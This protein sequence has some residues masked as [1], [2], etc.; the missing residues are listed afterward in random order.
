MTKVAVLGGTGYLA[1][2]IKS[3][4]TKKKNKFIFFSRK[5]NSKFY[6]NNILE[7]KNTKI[8]SDLKIIIHLAG[9][10]QLQLKKNVSLIK[11][12]NYITEKICDLCL[13]N[14][15]KLI[16][17][18]S[19]QVY[20]NYGKVDI[21]NN[22]KIDLKKSY[23]KSHIES[24]KII[25]QKFINKKNMFT[26]IRLGNVFGFKKYKNIREVNNNLINGFC[27]S[28]LKKKKF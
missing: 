7:K 8:L 5:K 26:I 25:N 20:S 23:S 18:S 13:K 28:A 21:Y 6:L 2:I 27:I 16:Y 17:I 1:S 9:P 19:M 14:N 3:Y 10:N 4:N 12:K 22:S 11:E 24:E 15:L